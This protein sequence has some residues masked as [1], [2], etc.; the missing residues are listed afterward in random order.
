MIQRYAGRGIVLINA[1]GIFIIPS[2]LNLAATMLFSPDIGH[3]FH[4]CA[5]AV[6][7]VS[8]GSWMFR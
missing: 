5:W 3:F 2:I 8:R 4:A 1:G 7:R 6:M